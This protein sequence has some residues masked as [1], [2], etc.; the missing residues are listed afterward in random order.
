MSDI[1]QIAEHV[2]DSTA[3]E[4]PFGIRVPIPQPPPV[5]GHHFAI[6]KLMVLE[7]A[8][9]V[10]MMAIFIPLARRIATGGAPRG[11]LWNAFE[12]ILLFVRNEMARP[13]IGR[14]DADRFLP[15]LWTAFFFI[16]F[17]NLMGLLPWAGSP[18]GSLSVTAALAVV[19]FST[20]VGAGMKRFGVVKFWIGLVP[21]VDLP[22]P[23]AIILKPF[24]FLIEV[25]GL[26]IRHAVLAIR[27]LANMFAGHLV[28]AVVLSFLVATANSWL[29]YGV[30][31]ASIFGA[32]MLSLLEL[33][34]AFLQAY[35]FV[36][37]SALFI[38]MAVH[39]H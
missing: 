22:L 35:I 16:L 20:A 21:R 2:K 19:A 24:I 14:H 32:T 23:L 9:A 5:W 15:F 4:L 30:M 10:A 13:A 11:R 18:T 36:F 38:G 28:L 7:L 26:F 3:F 31:P 29:W 27:L 39:Q 1:G 17:S 8:L 25:A 12:T 33:L 37:L 34:V 6:T